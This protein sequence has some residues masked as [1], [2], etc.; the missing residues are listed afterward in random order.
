MERRPLFFT[1][2]SI[3]ISLTIAYQINNC[4]KINEPFNDL[5]PAILFTLALSILFRCVSISLNVPVSIAEIRAQSQVDP[6]QNWL[7]VRVKNPLDSVWPKSVLVLSL[8]TIPAMLGILMPAF[9]N[10]YS[11]ILYCS[12]IT[13]GWSKVDAF[14]HANTHYHFFRNKQLQ[15]RIDRVLLRFLS[16]YFTYIFNVIFARIPHWYT[17][18]H[19]VIHH[20][21]DNGIEDTQ[22]TLSYD[23][24]SFFDFVRCA[25]RFAIS[26]LTSYDIIIYLLQKRRTKALRTILFGMFIFYGFLSAVAIWNWRFVLVV[27]MMRY[28]GLLISAIGFFQEHG[29]VDSSDP[30][31]IYRNSLHYI[32]PDNSHGSLGDD[33]H[34]EHHLHPVVHW[35]N[36]VRLAAT[37]VQRYA[38]ENS[39]GFLDGP[40]RQKEYYLKLWQGDFMGLA[41]LFVIVGRPNVTDNEVADLLWKRTR[42]IYEQK[43]PIAIEKV[44]KVAGRIAGY[45]VI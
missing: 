10:F 34:I 36:Y 13:I 24:A 42:P 14:E 30:Q 35:S 23:R 21:E 33:I 43:R 38:N 25:N 29:M 22:S 11:V 1:T 4:A 7:A 40:G 28:I 2:L 37:N 8:A 15:S 39:L 17:I 18:Q 6:V 16:V 12:I 19:S 45:L 5:L 20:A 31:N 44:D 26:G 3:C 9:F 32:T 41:S 27:L